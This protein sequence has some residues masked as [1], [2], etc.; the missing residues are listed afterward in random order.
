MKVPFSVICYLASLAVTHSGLM[1]AAVLLLTPGNSK[2][3]FFALRANLTIVSF[4]LN[5]IQIFTVNY[6][7]SIHLIKFLA[8][9]EK[10]YLID[11]GL[12]MELTTMTT[13][14]LT[15]QL[16]PLPTT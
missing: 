3:I 6:Y 11:A 16:N 4:N 9:F 13:P 10:K 14:L 1:L 2:I 8:F 12:E 15:V 5:W 7:Y